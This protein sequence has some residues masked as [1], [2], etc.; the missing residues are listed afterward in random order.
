MDNFKD[1]W[2]Q[3]EAVPSNLSKNFQL[4]QTQWNIEN[5]Y[6]LR[7]KKI[8]RTHDFLTTTHRKIKSIIIYV[9]L[10]AKMGVWD[11][12]VGDA[13]LLFF[14]FDNVQ[15]TSFTFSVL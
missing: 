6:A 13:Y 5:T 4:Q 11:G 1:S 8:D 14:T 10:L 3:Y 7:K 2:Q 12:G 15:S 9:I